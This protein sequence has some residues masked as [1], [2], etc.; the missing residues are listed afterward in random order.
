[1]KLAAWQ[2]NVPLLIDHHEGKRIGTVTR[3]DT[4]KDVD[5]DWLTASCDLY[6]DGPAWIRKGTPASFKSALLRE[7]S[8]VEGY[9]YG[10]HIQ[11]VSLLLREKPAEP[12]ARVALLYESDRTPVPAPRVVDG[13]VLRPATSSSTTPAAA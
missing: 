10:A 6:P 2:P 9:I 7:S 5:G 3:L 13:I 11:E 4:F 1:M 12:G 8:F